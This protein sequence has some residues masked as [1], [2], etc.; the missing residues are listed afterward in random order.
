MLFLNNSLLVVAK[1]V[2]CHTDLQGGKYQEQNDCSFG[3]GTAQQFYVGSGDLNPG[4]VEALYFQTEI[5]LAALVGQGALM[6]TEGP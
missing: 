2:E 5:G 4:P 3:N 6:A 1:S